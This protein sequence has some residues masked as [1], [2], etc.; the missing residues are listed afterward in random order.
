MYKNNSFISLL[1]LCEL[2]EL[3]VSTVFLDEEDFL[4][5]ILI[6]AKEVDWNQKDVINRM[7][8]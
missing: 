3:I 6:F 4:T 8:K 2:N 5:G 1:I 7:Q